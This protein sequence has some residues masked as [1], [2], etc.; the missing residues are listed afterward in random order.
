[1]PAGE[2]ATATIGVSLL[3][4]QH[5]FYKDLE[6]AMRTTAAANQIELIIQSAEMDPARQT[7]QIENFLT[8][9]VDAVV[10]CPCDSAGVAPVIKRCQDANVPVFTADIKA[11]GSTGVVSHI[12][13]D[14]VAG[15]RLA[16]ETMAKLIGDSG[17]VVIIDHP[18]V[19][20]VQDRVRGFEEEMKRHPNITIVSK[21]SAGG[22]RDRAFAITENMLQ[23]HPNLGGIFAINDDTALGALRAAG[24]RQLVIIGYDG[25]PEARDAIKKG[26]AL[27]ADV[28]QHPDEIGKKTIETIVAHLAGKPVDSEIPVPVGVID[29]ASLTEG[30]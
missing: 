17:E 12:A 4:Q 26:T 7:S 14:N 23:A 10:I 21:P 16:A 15:G 27:K 1:L 29:Q 25:T 2:E 13:S 24:D 5:D 19:T 30:K 3:T 18:E 9:G 8:R 22:T 6:A 28:V 20:S 11:D